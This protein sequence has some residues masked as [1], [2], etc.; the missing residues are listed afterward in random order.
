MTDDV[1]CTDLDYFFSEIVASH[2]HFFAFDFFFEETRRCRDSVPD[3]FL[4]A[5]D[6]NDDDDWLMSSDEERDSG[7][8]VVGRGREEAE[9]GM[10]G[11]DAEKVKNKMADVSE[12]PLKIFAQSRILTISQL[13]N[14][15]EGY[16]EGITAGKEST[17]QQGFDL[18]F[19]DVGAPL[20][21][22]VG[23][24]K[25]KASAL[26]MFV[27]GRGP[28]SKEAAKSHVG[29]GDNESLRGQLAQLLK[30]IEA[31][32]LEH[33]AERDYEAEEHELMHAR[34]AQEGAD[35]RLPPR[36][37]AQEKAKREAILPSFT[38][39]LNQLSAQI[40]TSL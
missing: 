15:Q 20:G 14:E 30:E 4:S 12:S 19:R 29:S 9:L 38:E 24:L 36:E 18:S 3:H 35:I 28:L 27:Q 22:K 37:T 32:E 21:R 11:R 17:L 25:G 10:G 34:E 31:I 23:I 8:E 26:T 39:R 16:R 40:L 2:S 5:M 7:K 33:V 1:R 6:D 13:I